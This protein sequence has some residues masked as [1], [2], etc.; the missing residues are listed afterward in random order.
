[1]MAVIE[2][3]PLGLAAPGSE[4]FRLIEQ[5]RTIAQQVGAYQPIIKLVIYESHLLCG[6]GEYERAAVVAQ[7][8]IADAERHGLSRT[9]GA[10]LGDQRGRAAALPR[11]LGRGRALR[12]AGP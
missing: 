6:V 9:S 8:G 7:E 2:A 3:G 1:M 5:A 12:R 4:A 10:F 11:P